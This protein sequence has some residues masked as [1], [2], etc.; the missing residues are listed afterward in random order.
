MELTI[1]DVTRIL[2]AKEL[3]LIIAR[4]RIAELEA[5]LAPKAEEVPESI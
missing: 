1:D 5:Q 4:N 2:G 3:E